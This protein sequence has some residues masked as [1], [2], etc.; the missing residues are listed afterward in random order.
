MF[1]TNTFSGLKAN[2][3]IDASYTAIQKTRECMEKVTLL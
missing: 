2:F 1:L 3:F